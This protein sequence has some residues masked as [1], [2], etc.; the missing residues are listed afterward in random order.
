MTAAA[1]ASWRV[2]KPVTH[3]IPQA[4]EKFNAETENFSVFLT[5]S[6][7]PIEL[8]HCRNASGNHPNPDTSRKR[9]DRNHR[10]HFTT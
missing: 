1:S 7:V 8:Q 6:C 10:N 4:G 2:S 5:I 3:N 9:G